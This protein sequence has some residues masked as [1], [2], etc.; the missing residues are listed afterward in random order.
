MKCLYTVHTFL[1][2]S[3]TPSSYRPLW[4]GFSWF[5]NSLLALK[6]WD[7]TT[8]ACMMRRETWCDVWEI[9][10]SPT[11]LTPVGSMVSYEQSSLLGLLW[12]RLVTS[13]SLPWFVCTQSSTAH[14]HV[15]MT[16]W[17]LLKFLS[18]DENEM[19]YTR[20]HKPIQTISI[21][22]QP[23]SSPKFDSYHHSLL[24]VAEVNKKIKTLSR[25]S[26]SEQVMI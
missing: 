11:E 19:M 17:I 25:F 4:V 16:E 26:R 22:N 13:L 10:L 3:Q 7:R 12:P 2:V 21:S 8:Y 14:E 1:F 6:A 5:R 24:R 18:E 23:H 20:L 15:C 9:H